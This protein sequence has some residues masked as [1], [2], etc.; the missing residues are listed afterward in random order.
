MTSKPASR[1]A[2]AMILAPRSW[3]SRPGL[4][5]RTR[6]GCWSAMRRHVRLEQLDQ[7]A[8]GCARLEEGDIAVRA[9]SGGLVDQLD[10]LVAQVPQVFHDIG[11]A[12]AQVVQPGP[13]TL[14]K[15]GHRGIG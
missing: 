12:E 8:Q 10:A 2:R 14:E 15:A 9:R 4:A 6:T 11:R 13:P 3:P 7:H 5:I 1:N